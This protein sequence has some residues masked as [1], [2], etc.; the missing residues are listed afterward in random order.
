MLMEKR[1]PA[2]TTD[3]TVPA[4]GAPAPTGRVAAILGK[5]PPCILWRG[6]WQSL[7]IGDIGHTPGAFE[8]LGKQFPGARLILWPGVL[9]HGSRDFLCQAFPGVRIAESCPATDNGSFSFLDENHRPVV[10]VLAGAWEEADIMVHG[11]GS[12]FGARAHLAAWHRTTEKPY[13]VFGVSLDPISGIGP[14]LDPEGGTLAGIRERIGKLPA[15]HLDEETRWIIDH[16]SFMFVRDSLSLAYLRLQGVCT[17]VLEFGPDSQF[18]M[19]LRDDARG[20]DW[21]RA[22][23]LETKKFI[24]VIP[25]LRYT[26]YKLYNTAPGADDKIRDAINERTAGRDHEKLRELMILYVRQTGG[27]VMTCPEMTY[28]SS[29]ARHMLIDPLPDD[30][31]KQVV[32]RDSYWLPD[33]AASIYANAQAVISYDCHSPIIALTQGTPGVYVRQPTDTCKGQMYRDL[34]LDEWFFEIE[35]TDGRQLWAHLEN[36]LRAPDGSRARVA[37]AMTRV[38]AAQNRMLDVLADSIK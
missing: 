3:D 23:N 31:K 22:N 16:A 33:E 6:S 35:E 1:S 7:N 14:N 38:R 32:W 5:R 26:P 34:G 17:P 13:G 2:R 4:N 29:L 30:V 25:R 9:G 11:S 15:T 12:G 10:P 36:I 37:A 20:D 19:T 27:R 18:G 21:R 8:L 28:Q 24:C